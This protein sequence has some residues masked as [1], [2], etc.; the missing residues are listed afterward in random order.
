MPRSFQVMAMKRRLIQQLRENESIDQRHFAKRI[1]KVVEADFITALALMHQYSKRPT[2]DGCAFFFRALVDEWLQVA[3]KRAAAALLHFA[4]TILHTSSQSTGR[5][6]DRG[7]HP[8]PHTQQGHP[9][10]HPSSYPF[11]TH[12][13]MEWTLKPTTTKG[14]A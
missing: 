6:I 3:F 12:V 9:S 14:N 2:R 8:P 13:E 11:H 1:E 4:K 7:I 5:R 10:L